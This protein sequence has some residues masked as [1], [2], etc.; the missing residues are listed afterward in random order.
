MDKMINK[1]KK[2]QEEIVGFVLIIVLVCVI[3]MILLGIMIH[4]SKRDTTYKS[5]EYS[6]YIASLMEVNSDCIVYSPAYAKISD[7][8]GYCI[9]SMKCSSEITAC[10]S[11]NLTI[12]NILN[13]S[14]RYGP[15]NVI[16]GYDFKITYNDNSSRIDE[17][18]LNITKGV[19][20]SSI[21]GTDYLLPHY[22]GSIKTTIK[23]CS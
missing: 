10:Q 13:S 7:L 11:L 5:T 19:C 18:I 23:V 12:N 17:Q 3:F 21:I 9:D 8:I 16:K 4:N 22:P 14:L 20:N 15:K 1:N 2:A 6:Q